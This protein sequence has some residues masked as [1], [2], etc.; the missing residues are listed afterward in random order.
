MAKGRTGL[1]SRRS[2]VRARERPPMFSGAYD[3]FAKAVESRYSQNRRYSILVRYSQPRADL[4]S[5]SFS[6]RFSAGAL[7][8]VFPFDPFKEL[9]GRLK[10]AVLRR[11]QCGLRG[12]QFT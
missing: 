2:A 1:T 10:P 11:C 9:L 3:G 12:D 4:I 5:V 6:N 8:L 7:R